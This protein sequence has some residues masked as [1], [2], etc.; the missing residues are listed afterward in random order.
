MDGWNGLGDFLY[1]TVFG[2]VYQ[3]SWKILWPA[4]GETIYMTVL[5]TLLSYIIGI[6]LGVLLVVTRKGGIKP[7]P[8]F[9]MALGTII[10]FL[11]SIPFI[12]LLVMLLNVTLAVTGRMTGTMTISFPLTISAF[13]YV[14]RMVESSLM[15]VDGGVIEAAK[16]MGSTTWQIIWKVLLPEAKPSLINGF[17]I[18]MTTIL[19]YTTMASVAAGGGLGATAV[20]YGLSYRQYDIMYAASIMLVVLVQVITVAGTSLSR[21]KDH[22]IR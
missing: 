17:S 2:F 3:R 9:N 12:I 21:K 14:A 15:E 16:A 22:R 20:T 19:G 13:P 4:L 5:S 18:C 7:L 10:N 1:K 11:R 6:A 8:K